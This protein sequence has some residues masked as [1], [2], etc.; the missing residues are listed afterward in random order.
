MTM[1]TGFHL[2]GIRCCSCGAPGDAT[3][4]IM[5]PFFKPSIIR[6]VITMNLTDIV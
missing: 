2:Y 4:N 6:A 3:S 1:A 5:A